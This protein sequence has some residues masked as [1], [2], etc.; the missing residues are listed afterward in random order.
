MREKALSDFR[1]RYLMEDIPYGLVS[2][3]SLD[4]LVN[5]L[6]RT[7]DTLI[8][9]ASIIAQVDYN[10]K[11]ANLEKHGLAGLSVKQVNELL[12]DGFIQS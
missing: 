1:R 7:I 5:V 3:S 4:K 9:P 10:R 6:T 12:I 11:G 2:I 8:Q